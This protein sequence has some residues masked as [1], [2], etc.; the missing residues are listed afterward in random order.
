M[1]DSVVVVGSGLM[2]AG[3]AAT[4]AIAGHKTILVDNTLELAQKGKEKASQNI[5]ELWQNGLIDEA[6][7][8][9]AKSLIETSAELVQSCGRAELVIEAIFE[10]LALKQDLFVRLDEILPPEVPLLSNTSGLRITDISAKCTLHPERMLTAHFWFPAH[11][12]PLIE[13]VVGDRS[14]YNVAVKMKELFLKWKKAPVIVKRDLPGQLAN[15]LFQAIIR[16]A[17]NI[18]EIG[19]AEPD[20]IDTAVKAGMGIRMPVWGVLEH[21]DAV[22]V[23]LCDH[24]QDTVLPGISDRKDAS[25]L[26]K[27]KVADGDLG[28]KTKKGFYDWNT[29]SMDDLVKTRNDFIISTVKFLRSREK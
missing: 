27:K 24:V 11:L 15:R 26:F 6:N 21:V 9:S 29:K 25:P 1:R 22:G 18:V 20:D 17:V 28:Y 3:I 12:V 4:S 2:G 10:N 19:L 23:D 16:E 7:A 8:N 5:D 14:D 13:V